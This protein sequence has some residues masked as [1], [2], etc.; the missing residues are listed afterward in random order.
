M[1]LRTWF[2][3]TLLLLLGMITLILL[4][5]TRFDIPVEKLKAK[6]TNEESEFIEIQGMQIHYRDEGEGTPLVLLHGTSAS[7][8]T[9]EAWT[10][11]LKKNYRVLR[12]DLPAYGL[13]GPHPQ[14]KYDLNMYLSVLHEFF[15]K[16]GI[17][18]FYLGGNSFGG[19]LAWEYALAYPQEVQKMILVDASAYPSKR[20]SPWVFRLAKIPML[21]QIVRYVTPKFFFRNNLEQVYGNDAK[22]T[23]ELLNR[24][25]ELG[26]RDGNRQAFID[27]IQHISKNHHEQIKN[28]QT[29]TLILWGEKDTWIPLENGQKLD[30]DLPNSKLIVYPG[31]GHVPMEEDPETTVKD[32]ADFLKNP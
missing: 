32:V 29:P 16:K 10:Q 7:L 13:T 31:L 20:K 25:Y 14:R 24:Y 28:I 6:Y 18:E 3:Y 21:N 12:L 8:H 23:D 27:R 15:Q 17:R 5:Y 26:L 22:I 2:R 30:A 11:V 19:L 1:K 9:W 4:I